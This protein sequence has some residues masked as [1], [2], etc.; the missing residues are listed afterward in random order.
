MELK[1]TNGKYIGE[2]ELDGKYVLAEF[3]NDHNYVEA[4]QLY[5]ELDGYNDS[6]PK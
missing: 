4:L 6:A 1:T 3:F 5:T 2:N